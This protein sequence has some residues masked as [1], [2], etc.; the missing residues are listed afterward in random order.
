MLRS[1]N[2]NLA[3]LFV[4]N[5]AFGLGA[6]LINPLFPLFLESTGA[7]EAQIAYIISAG[8]L[9]ATLLM[10]PSG[11]IVDRVGKKLFLVL[12]AVLS[13]VSIYMISG[14]GSWSV[15]M[16][17]YVVYSLVGAFFMP[18]RMS[19][20]SENATPDNRA[21]LFGLM[22]LAWP[23]TG[24]MSPV[25]SGWIVETSGWSNV[26]LVATVASG[27]SLLPALL[28][29]EKKRE[30]GVEVKPPNLRGL[31]Q[32]DLLRVLVVM[33]IAPFLMTTAMGA[34]NLVIPL[35]LS[36][37]YN[38]SPSMIGLFFT[39]SSVLTLFAQVPS[40][41]LAD[42]FDPKRILMICTGVIPMFFA[43]WHFTDNWVLLLVSY[44]LSVG[45]WS[46]MWPSNLTILSMNIPRELQGAGFG[47]N[48][49]GVRLGFTVGP[50]IGSYL[51]G[52]VFP[53]APFLFAAF[54]ALLGLP[55]I[56]F[57]KNRRNLS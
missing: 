45:I 51:Y 14:S 37:A 52:N 17:F 3:Y 13:A 32:R 2:R 16:P 18:A 10:F 33:F 22:N 7:S 50:F 42:R 44:A 49:T 26:Y 5:I 25:L 23:L 1:L 19:M 54:S 29:K 30:P 31:L 34:V 4:I 41:R 8:S 40:G 43:V 24:I 46:V 53:T 21:T 57:L 56:S 9:A 38:L 6:Q 39:A 48:S 36:S 15:I 35:Y 20:I 28:I 55:V 12:N 47:I 11:I 27:V